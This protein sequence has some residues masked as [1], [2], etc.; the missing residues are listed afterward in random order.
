MIQINNLQKKFGAKTAVN[1]DNYIINQGDMLGLV[2]NNGAGKTTL[3]R[4]ILDLLQ[5]DRGNVTIKDIDVCKSEDWK[6][7]TGA[8]IDDG[9]LIDYLTPEEYFHFIGKMYGL[10]KEEVDERIAPFERFMNGEVMGQKKFI[11]NFSAGNKQKIG[12]ISAMLHHPQLLILDE[13]FNF[14]D[15]SSQSIIKQLLKKYNEE[16]GATVIISSHNLNHTVDVCPR[17]A[18]LE[19]GVIIRD[20]QN[21]NNSAEKEL[22]AYFNVSVEEAVEVENNT[23]EKNID[24]RINMK[25]SFSYIIVL[26]GLM[27]CLSSCHTSAPRLDYKA[28]AQASVRLGMDIELTDNHKLYVNAAEWIGTPYRAGGDSRHGTDCSGLVSQLYKKTYRMRLSRSTDGQLKESNK[29]ARRNLR[30]GDLVF[31]TSRSSR[32]KVAHVGIYLKDGKFIHASTSQGVIV[33]SLKEKYY[34]QHWLCGGRVK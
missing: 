14:L 11:R 18:L 19:H 13:P 21:E 5:A 4:L 34:T 1:I 7:F 10:K 23:D 16:H 15:P 2:G 17:I 20:I 30:E 27:F 31:F 12:I 24:R 32:K 29:I 8:F 25:Q 28:L 6:N 33:S 22:E 26:L 9:F 3:F